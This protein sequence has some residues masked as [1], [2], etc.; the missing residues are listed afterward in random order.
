MLKTLKKLSILLLAIAFTGCDNDDSK[1]TPA[2]DDPRTPLLIGSG[3]KVWKLVNTRVL[4]IDE[5]KECEE[6]NTL[7]FNGGEFVDDNGSVACLED[8]DRVFSGEWD[9]RIGNDGQDQITLSLI[10]YDI[11]EL[12]ESS[13]KIKYIVEY[14]YVPQ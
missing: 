11:L 7:T 14:H 3:T 8:N 5:L 9:F 1:L 13:L 12:T 6:D 4:D 10:P 2:P